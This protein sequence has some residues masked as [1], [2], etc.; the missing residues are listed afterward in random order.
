M[1]RYRFAWSNLPPQ[2]LKSLGAAHAPDGDPVNALRDRFGARPKPAFV[3]AAWPTLL[4]VWLPADS[5]SRQFVAEKMTS[6]SMGRNDSNIRSKQAQLDYLRSCRN[7][8]TLHGVVLTAFLVAGEVSQLKAP[9]VRPVQ[10]PPP[11]R[12][13][14]SRRQGGTSPSRPDGHHEADKPESEG[15]D[16]W[17]EV[18]L[19][20]AF[21]LSAVQRDQDGDIPLRR[22]STV[23]YVR[24]H[25]GE[26]PFLEIFAPLVRDFRMSPAV[27]EAVNAINL[28]VPMAKAM[29]VGG[30]AQIV[31]S[32]QLLTHTLSTAEFLLAVDL[33]SHAADH[34]DTAL[35]K[36][37][38]GRTLLEDESDAIAV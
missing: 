21:G 11:A 33:V 4:K 9:A 2:L 30:G 20:K 22:G 24:P 23:L 3:R 27:Y 26:S 36:Q 34:F 19:M 17:I 38:G 13:T 6:L 31:L 12:R 7:T 32:S 5:P 14:E 10:E 29:V 8:P 18:T 35:E 15:L 37:F 1:P 25:D 28:Q 16:K